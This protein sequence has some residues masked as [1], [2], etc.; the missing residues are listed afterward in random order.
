[1]LHQVT[2]L[3][4]L[5]FDF[6]SYFASVEQHLNIHLR[7]KPIAIVP[8]MTDSTC[9]IAASFEAKKFG[10]K[11]G[12]KIYEAKLLCKDLIPIILNK[13]YCRGDLIV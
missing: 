7:N 6:D 9:A 5:Y 8:L 1:M 11:T 3:N 12:T 13:L 10:I 2:K 4:W